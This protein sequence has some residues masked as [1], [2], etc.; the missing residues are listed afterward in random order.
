LDLMGA[1]RSMGSSIR[2]YLPL[3]VG[4]EKRLAVLE[5][6]RIAPSAANMQDWMFVRVRDAPIRARST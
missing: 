5:A 6:G 1:I 3:P 4:D 2:S